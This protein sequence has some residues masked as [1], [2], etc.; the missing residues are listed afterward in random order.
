MV[1]KHA[2]KLTQR[3]EARR[4]AAAS[5]Q[6]GA[7]PGELEP[8]TPVEVIKPVAQPKA[9]AGEGFAAA[10]TAARAA[11]EA[12]EN[13]L[14]SA[15]RL[16]QVLADHKV[17]RK[18]LAE[19][20]GKSEGWLSKRLGLLNAT[21]DIQHLIEAGQLSESEYYDNRANVAAGVRGKGEGA[22]YKRM[23]TVTIPIEAARALADVLQ[24][25]AK[26]HELAPVRV[27]KNTTKKD[28]V[29]I[30]TLRSSEIRG[31]IS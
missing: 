25:L 3:I 11:I 10:A 22:Q 7:A 26:V 28:L 29:N 30:L 24:H 23:P 31:V 17:K 18:D 12:G 16:A 21:R 6:G 19:G 4:A 13:P 27:D 9:A 20:L 2:D 5:K 15:R 8:S 14:V 1:D